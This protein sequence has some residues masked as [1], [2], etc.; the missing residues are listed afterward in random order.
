[1]QI[2]ARFTFEKLVF[3]ADHDVHLVV[4]L[5]AP[6]GSF[7][8]PR[9]P[10]CIIPVLD[11]SG[12]MRGQKLH[13][14]KQ[15]L[16]KL[17]DHLTTQ[18]YFGLVRFSD[19]AVV[20]APVALVTPERKEELKTMIGK[21]TVEGN[22]NLSTGIVT[23]LEIANKMDL[24]ASTLVRIIV[25]TDGQPT[26]G[27]TTQ[28]AL[29][30][31]LGKAKGR[32][33][34]SAF[35]YGVDANQDILGAVS[36][37]GQGNYAFIRDPDAAL[38][39]FG[40]ELGGLLSTYAQNVVV[41]LTPHNG[42]QV[43][44][45]LTDASVTTEDDGLVR[46]KVPHI[47]SEEVFSVV[48][49]TKLSKQKSAGPRQVNALDVRVTYQ[50]LDENGKLVTKTE[51]TKARIQFVKTGEEQEKPTHE[52]DAIVARAQMVKAQV[53]AEE[54]AKAGNF[55]GARAS[56]DAAVNSSRSRGHL[57]V[58]S[59]GERVGGLYSSVQSYGSSGGNRVGLR[60]AMT[61]GYATSSLDADDQ[62]LVNSVATCD[63]MVQEQYREIFMAEAEPEKK[64]PEPAKEPPP[65]AKKHEGATKT[66]SSRW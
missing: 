46:V 19:N 18:D 55:V 5:T 49:A 24:P 4:D 26:H 53:E 60:A 34:V 29:V 27:V 58:A 57:N 3:D 37:V 50:V 52:V 28:P 7:E 33:S 47:L 65:S 10:L 6:K 23:A 42:H 54:A 21:F 32:A 17:V 38:A 1:M 48:V 61:R 25:L 20:D 66:R 36:E 30:D 43:Q 31:L 62:V 14:A 9:A 41:E 13:Y 11:V 44:E 22:T 16:L 8:A 2:N 63:N 45:V 59:V 15:S 64:A 56:L 40:K 39:A 12:S 35:G 51:E